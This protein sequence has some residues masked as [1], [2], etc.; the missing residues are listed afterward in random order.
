MTEPMVQVEV[1][2]YYTDAAAAKALLEVAGERA[3]LVNA[4][5]G[6]IWTGCIGEVRIEVP[7]SD[8]PKAREIL[9][10]MREVHRKSID[11]GRSAPPETCLA[12]G[13]PL[14][15]GQNT[16]A[17][18]GWTFDGEDWTDF[19]NGPVPTSLMRFSLS[20]LGSSRFGLPA[21]SM[22]AYLDW[23]TR[24]SLRLRGWEVWRNSLLG[25][26]VIGSNIDGSL[27]DLLDAAAIAMGRRESG[28]YFS[29]SMVDA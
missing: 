7:T 23:C 28:V 12:C 20:P 2:K 18:C 26:I 16:C 14:Q 10:R 3:F 13:I 8:V 25:H 29:P 5:S 27:Q 15:I 4:Y 11:A 22:Q 21:E 19:A 24:K 1:F 6:D 9:E 17:T